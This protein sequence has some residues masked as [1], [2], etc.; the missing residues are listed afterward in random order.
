MIAYLDSS[1]V[2][3]MLLGESTHDR[4]YEIWDRAERVYST[5]L[6]YVEVASAVHRAG[7][8]GRISEFEHRRALQRLDDLWEDVEIV[9]L[10]ESLMTLSAVAAGAEGLRGFDAVHCAAG[11]LIATHSDAVAV[12]GDRKLLDAW[13]NNGVTVIDIGA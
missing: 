4:C 10:G 1:V 7:R 5:R 6:L 9:D 2:V 13:S 3:S 8:A 12:A 11:L